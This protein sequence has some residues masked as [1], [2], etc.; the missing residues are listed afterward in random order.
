MVYFVSVVRSRELLVGFL[1]VRRIPTVSS[2]KALVV[3]S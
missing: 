1:V 2:S 3:S